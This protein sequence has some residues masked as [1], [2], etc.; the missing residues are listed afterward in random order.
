MQDIVNKIKSLLARASDAGASQ[1]EAETCMAKAHGLLAKHNMSMGDLEKG[2]GADKELSEGHTWNQPWERLV[3]GAVAELYFCKFYFIPYGTSHVDYVLVGR[4]SNRI[5]AINVAQ[6]VVETGKRLARE[7][8]QDN[9]GNSVSL[10]N[11][12]KKG[13]ATAI[14]VKARKLKQD[15]IREGKQGGTGTALMVLDV[16]KQTELENAELMPKRLK[17]RK[18]KGATDGLAATAGVSAGSKVSLSPSIGGD[19]GSTL[20]IGKE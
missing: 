5:T 7:Y 1:A 18:T 16:Y 2:E 15:A 14:H 11:S 12:F 6:F 3:W 10:S 4:E 9:Y 17:T 13:F 20:Q 8:A 19:R